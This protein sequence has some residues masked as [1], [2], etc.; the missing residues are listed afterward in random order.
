M[1]LPYELTRYEVKGLTEKENDVV[2]YISFGFT[3]KEISDILNIKQKTVELRLYKIY[4]KFNI[5]NKTELA[6]KYT[7]GLIK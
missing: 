2:Y 1:K 4:R 7:L 3:N 5:R 6:V